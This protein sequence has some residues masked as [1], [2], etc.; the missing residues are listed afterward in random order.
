MSKMAELHAEGV[1][2]LYSYKQGRA[3]GL[4]MISSVAKELMAKLQSDMEEHDRQGNQL[5]ALSV[6]AQILGIS[7]FVSR[8]T[9]ELSSSR[10]TS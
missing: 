5:L 2:D 7:T 1:T 10:R 9:L 4:E 6:S 8:I 3:D